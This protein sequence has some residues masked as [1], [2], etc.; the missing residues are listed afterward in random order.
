MQSTGRA[1]MFN[2]QRMCLNKAMEEPRW[3]F[4]CDTGTGKTRIGLEL[5]DQKRPINADTRAL[6]LSPLPIIEAAWLTQAKEWTPWLKVVNGRNQKKKS[7]PKFWDAMV[8]NYESLTALYKKTHPKRSQRIPAAKRRELLA[9]WEAFKARFHLVVLDESVKIKSYNSKVWQAVD[10]LCDDSMEYVYPMSGCPA[11]NS[12]LEYYTQQKLVRNPNFE[13]WATWRMF[14]AEF[15]YQPVNEQ[16]WLWEPLYPD[17]EERIV[18]LCKARTTYVS[19]EDCL[20]LKD[21][22]YEPRPVFL[23]KAEKDAYNEM[24]REFIIQLTENPLDVVIAQNVLS[25]VMKLRQ[26]TA[27]FVANDLGWHE[28]GETKLKA[29]KEI[30]D[31]IG[32]KQVLIFGQF[33]AEIERIARTLG[34]S[35]EILYGGMSDSE[36][37]RVVKGFIDGT[38]QYLVAH[39]ASAK[40]GFTFVNATYC[41]WAS[42]SYNYDEWYQGNQ[43][44][45]R[46]G[47]DVSTTHLA[48][49]AEGTIDEVI[50]DAVQGKHNLKERLLEMLK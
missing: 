44:I 49:L 12:P 21:P 3:L 15:Y 5:V 45:H 39:P 27:G 29:L 14:R 19:K 26:M 7:F 24:R 4:A 30:L 9:E 38:Y 10:D 46:Y 8:W 34:D 35:A 6:I 23:N 2:H 48:L 25:Q 28:I 42:M 18:E 20:D 50:Y 1:P 17:A 33:R 13:K 43:R 37:E 47:Q 11:P 36:R 32:N 16:A 31:E 41:I 22:V 40:Y